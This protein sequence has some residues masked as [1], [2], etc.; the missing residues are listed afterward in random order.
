[1][2]EAENIIKDLGLIELAQF[3]HTVCIYHTLIRDLLNSKGF[4]GEAE[5]IIKDF[6]SD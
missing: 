4:V 3:I 1:M 6:L 5:N 2:R